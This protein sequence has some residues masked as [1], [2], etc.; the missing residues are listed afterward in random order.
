MTKIEDLRGELKTLFSVRGAGMMDSVFPPLVFYLINQF[1]DLNMALIG[2][3]V[4]AVGIML[5]RLLTRQKIIYAIGGLV[6]VLIA[7]LLAK[8]SDSQSGFY[9]P[10]FFTGTLTVVAC[11]VSVITKRPLAAWSSM[12]TRRWP[13][14]WYWHP[15]V[16]PAYNEVTL[17][18]ALAFSARLGLEYDL[19]RQGAVDALGMARIILGWP[20]TIAVLIV[21]YLY[22]L[23]RLHKLQ[24]PSVEE[25]NAGVNPPWV[26][27]QRGF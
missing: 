2:S 10:G 21:S 25:F 15:R 4:S 24:G 6:G 17:I 22:G 18:W 9:L 13:L 26:G 5:V 14:K 20:F 11:V 19:Y 23:W 1:S 8:M 16:Q 3:V 7:I 12:L 27:Q